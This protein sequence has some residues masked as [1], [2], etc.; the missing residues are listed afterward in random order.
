MVLSKRDGDLIP[1]A[2]ARS[3][4]RQTCRAAD[5]E[6]SGDHMPLR[7]RDGVDVHID[8]VLQRPPPRAYYIPT[9]LRPACGRD[10]PQSSSCCVDVMASMC[11]G[12]R[13]ECIAEVS[14]NVDGHVQRYWRSVAYSMLLRYRVNNTQSDTAEKGS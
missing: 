1:C 4:K 6:P 3:L 5:L 14:Y 13:N 12:L 8:P 7:L 9:S 2:R 10:G 11:V